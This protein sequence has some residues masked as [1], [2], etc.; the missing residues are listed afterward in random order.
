MPKFSCEANNV[1]NTFSRK[2]KCC[3][4]KRGVILVIATVHYIRVYK[5]ADTRGRN[6]RVLCTQF[7]HDIGSLGS[8][9]WVWRSKSASAA[10][11]CVP[12][13]L[14]KALPVARCC[15]GAKAHLAHTHFYFVILII[16][17]GSLGIALGPRYSLFLYRRIIARNYAR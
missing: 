8:S 5:G 13:G 16:I 11:E 10:R 7:F 17:C 15:G 14:I 4:S 2:S 12:R 3:L 1:S 6:D 9:C